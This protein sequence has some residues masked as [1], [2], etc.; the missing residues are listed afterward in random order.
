MSE[1]IPDP[2]VFP[3]TFTDGSEVTVDIHVKMLPDMLAIGE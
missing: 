1:I 2:E 3:D